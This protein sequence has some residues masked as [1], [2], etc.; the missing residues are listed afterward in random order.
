MD[1]LWITIIVLF[2]LNV[3]T[4]YLLMKKP[5]TEN[6]IKSQKQKIK[7]NKGSSSSNDM[8]IRQEQEKPRK[9]KRRLFKRRNKSNIN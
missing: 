2:L 9:Q 3:W 6:N 7:R 1:K 5:T 4:I 8:D